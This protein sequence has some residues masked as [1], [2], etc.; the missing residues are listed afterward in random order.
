M[1]LTRFAINRPVI[2]AMVFLA[3]AIFGIFAYTQIGRAQ[4]PP[5]TEFPLVF[6]AADYPGASPQDM[7]KLVVKPLEDQLSDLQ[8]VEQ[9]TA[10]AQEGSAEVNVQFKIDTNIELAA[11]DVQRRVDTARVFMPSDLDPPLVGKAGSAAPTML[12][13]VSSTALSPT[14]LADVVTNQLIPQLKQI[15]NIQTVTTRGVKTREFHVEPD[16]AKLVGTNATLNDIFSAVQ[17]NNANVPGGRIDG[18]TQETTVAIHA[19]VNSANDLANIPLP[20]P[21]SSSKI[22]RIGDVASA[23]DSFADQR[24]ISHYNGQPRI[25]I[26]LDKV[27]SMDEVSETTIVRDALKKIEPQFP[28]LTFHEIEAPGDYTKQ[29]LNGVWQSLIEGIILTA[30][31]MMLFLH[32]WRNAAVVMIAI[33]TSILSTFIVMKWMG[34]TFDFMSLMGLSL[35]I[36]ILVDDSIVVLENITRHRDQGEDPMNAAING[37]TEIGS[38]AI[39]I[40][41]VDVIVFSPIAFLPGIVG[42]YL[43]EFGIVVVVATLFSL[44]VSFTLTPLLAGKWSVLKRSE[45]RPK[46][47]DRLK[48][49]WVNVG[50]AV[51]AVAIYFMPVPV[52]DGRVIGIILLALL[53]LNGFVQQYEKILN[54]YKV[55]VLNFALAHGYYV[56]FLCITLLLN[57]LMLMGGGIIAAIFD[58][59]LVVIVALG[60]VL[61]LPYRGSF[62][63]GKLEPLNYGMPGLSIPK[64]FFGHLR[65]SVGI[66]VNGQPRFAAERNA[67]RFLARSA[68]GMYAK[69]PMT[70]ATLGL[71]LA[72]ASVVWIFQPISTDFV[73][74]GQ[75][76][77]V[78]MSLTYPVGTP[79]VTTERGVDAISQAIQKIDGIE[80]VSS[81]VGYKSAGFGSINGGNYATL[82]A[83]TYKDRRKEQNQ[84]MVKIRKLAYLA[85]GG[86]FQVAGESGGGSGTPIFY[87]LTGP[88]AV[89]DA[90]AKKIVVF[91]RAT[92]GAVNVQSGAEGGAPRLNVQIDP[93]RAAILGV[94]PGAAATAARLAIA[95]GVATKVRTS[96]GLTDVR[97]QFPAARRNDVLN[98]QNVRIRAADGTL[99][100]LG[101]IATFQW[102]KAPTKIDRLDRARV[103]NVTGGVLPGYSLG[104]VTGPL[105]KKLNEPGFLPAGVH[106]KPQGDTQLM[107]QTFTSMGLALVTSFMLVYMLMVILY[108]SFLEP[109]IVMCSVPMAMVGALFGLAFMSRIDFS[110]SGTQSLN[111][112]SM[113]GIIMLFGL[114]AKNGILL[115]D[116]S[117][118]L[119]RKRGLRVRDAALQASGTRFRPILMTTFAMVFGML[120]LA[121]GFAEGSEWR[122]AIGTV[123]IGG[124]VSSLILTL[125]LV[126]MIYNTWMGFLERRGDERAVASEMQPSPIGGGREQPALVT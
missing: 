71:P 10:T 23:T 15:P 90:A 114:V 85:P 42:K 37:R 59:G 69:F 13:A 41:L 53:V 72:L 28:Q 83:D 101:S 78:R 87:A 60:L 94:Q 35:I 48:N 80:T 110:Q 52:V 74:G 34:L 44:L 88:D 70:L 30:I 63:A 93:M 99:V 5:G 32:A 125:F 11:I 39:A 19:D 79:I 66:K 92:P 126:P 36:G 55:H 51:A 116:Y 29:E 25:R 22:L 7:E 117:N 40:T 45:G 17:Q 123:I 43:K 95:G 47:L 24:Y 77:T 58:V 113:I 21:G 56:V 33:P 111:I 68:A 31:V 97:V 76:G 82:S 105:E 103:V 81:T 18:K 108:G 26:Q 75:T 89:L 62:E 1:W 3:L 119:H 115:V 14:A 124:L 73:P 91:L 4:N 8:N 61:G 67:W 57:A 50:I 54:W 64:I 16:A 106:L 122:Q 84:I 112:I 100:P 121:L 27:L 46:W 109:L 12:L 104:A 65:A 96:E 86:D 107:I 118:T 98:L 38:A 20:V 102:T 9:V 2:T 120:P 49:I 6:I